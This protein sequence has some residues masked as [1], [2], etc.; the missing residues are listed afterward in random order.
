[1]ANMVKKVPFRVDMGPSGTSS[2]IEYTFVAFMSPP[3]LFL[4]LF[5]TL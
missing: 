4:S 1:M 2:R 3:F 5:L